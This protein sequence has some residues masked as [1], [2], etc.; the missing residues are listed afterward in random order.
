VIKVASEP[1]LPGQVVSRPLPSVSG[2]VVS[3]VSASATT[4]LT[5]AALA[6]FDAL[7]RFVRRLGIRA[8]D[9]DDVLQ[10]V[11]MVL[12]ERLASVPPSKRKSF[13]FGTAFRVASEHR[14]KSWNTREVAAAF[15]EKEPESA[16]PGPDEQ[17]DDARA[18]AM[19]ER[20]L[21]ALPLDVRAVF[22]LYEIEE[23]TM[24]EIASTLG[25]A[26]G[27][28]ASR[29]RRGRAHFEGEVARAQRVRPGEKP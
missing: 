16:V 28:V 20:I 9:V 19:L 10:E 18:R 25:L 11:I 1:H 23:L 15:D 12:A 24:A 3:R 2:R 14:R 7:W 5:N 21:E 26:P 13:L 4:E 17:L 8:V 22:V 27:T 29:L 6:H